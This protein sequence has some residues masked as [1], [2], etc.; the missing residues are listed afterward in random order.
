MVYF[1][2]SIVG[3][4]QDPDAWGF[5]MHSVYV[6]GFRV[7][8]LWDSGLR[9]GFKF[10]AFNFLS[11]DG[12]RDSPGSDIGV[13]AVE[14]LARMERMVWGEGGWETQSGLMVWGS[15][16]KLDCAGPSI[17]AGCIW[18]LGPGP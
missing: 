11:I 9:D 14:A 18:H 16:Q 1:L 12:A 13:W 3:F 5:E 17:A 2:G 15:A 10:V 7:L 4:A 8:G 6:L